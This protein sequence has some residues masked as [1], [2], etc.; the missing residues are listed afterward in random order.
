MKNHN[1]RTIQSPI[2]CYY[3]SLEFTE[4]QSCYDDILRN[5]PNDYM[6]TVQLLERFLCDLHISA[7]CECSSVSD[8][9]NIILE[10][11]TENVVYK[12]HVLDLCE[13]LLLIKNVPKL[14]HVVE[15][16]RECKCICTHNCN[17]YVYV[18]VIF[19]L[20]SCKENVIGI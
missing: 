16:L 14:T 6:Q 13:R 18:C 12:K 19:L 8:A 10:C 4:L 5:M 1:I 3:V 15:A 7:I 20:V 17:I 9:N 11:L 2:I